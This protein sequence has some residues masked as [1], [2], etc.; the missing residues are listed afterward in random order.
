LQ[1]AADEIKQ[2][3]E[4]DYVVMNNK[5]GLDIAIEEIRAIIMSEKC[6]VKPRRIILP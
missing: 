2:V 6:K 5:D 4:F 3:S 1:S